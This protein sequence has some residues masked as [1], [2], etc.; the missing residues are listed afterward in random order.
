MKKLNF[1]TKTDRVIAAA[2]TV[3]LPRLLMLVCLVAVMLVFT[4]SRLSAQN[5]TELGNLLNN[6]KSSK[7][8]LEHAKAV[9]IESLCYDYQATVHVT[10]EGITVFGAD[11][12]RAE[13]DGTAL[14]KLT[15]AHPSFAQVEMLVIRLADLSET[16]SPL[17][18][19]LLQSFSNLKFVLLLC[20]FSCTEG[21]VGNFI[22]PDPHRAID[23]LFTVS[24]P[25]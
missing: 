12:K 21:S 2:I 13:T 3:Y 23:V 22:A 6:L 20:E 25:D 17:D 8:S 1:Y 10:V 7:S 24:I 19:S 16:V 4:A 9:Q 15:T 14:N 11:P 5:V 18:L